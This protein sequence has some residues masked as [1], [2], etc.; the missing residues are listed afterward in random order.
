M[1]SRGRVDSSANPGWSG[2]AA[3]HAP[4][5]ILFGPDGRLPI[6]GDAPAILR[7]VGDGR[8]VSLEEMVR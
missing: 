6:D 2:G 4:D 1:S 3:E 5:W 8:T 7:H